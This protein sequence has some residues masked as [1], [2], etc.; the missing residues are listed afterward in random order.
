[1]VEACAREVRSVC[2]TMTAIDS[3]GGSIGGIM[4]TVG[5]RAGASNI[6]PQE[7]ILALGWALHLCFR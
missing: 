4:T 3:G 1:M 5:A 7:Q 6:G 2:S